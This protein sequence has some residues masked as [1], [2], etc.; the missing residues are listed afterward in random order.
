MNAEDF[1]REWTF[2]TISP[3]IAD[4]IA[5]SQCND[6][7]HELLKKSP[8]EM[9]DGEMDVFLFSSGFNR[10]MAWARAR[11]EEERKW[12]TDGD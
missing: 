12:S 6:Q 1:A 9:N 5:S 10:G 11:M 8:V 3:D 4:H 7:F 2:E